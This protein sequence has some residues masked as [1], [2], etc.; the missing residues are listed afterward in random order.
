MITDNPTLNAI[1]NLSGYLQMLFDEDILILITDRD[2]V[3]YQKSSK[4]FDIGAH[5][6]DPI[7]NNTPIPKVIY[8][9]QPDNATIP[10]EAYGMEFTTTILPIKEDG[11]VVGTLT[12]GRSASKKVALTA[13][14][15]TLNDSLSQIALA[16]NQITG[17]VQ[18]LATMNEEILSESKE[19]SE[20]S[21]E[22]DN[23]VSFIQG[24]ASQTNLLGLNAAIEASRAGEAGRGFTIVA[25]EIRKLS[26]STN[27]SIKQID[28]VIK[29]ISSSVKNITEKLI[30][31]NEA[32]QSQSAALQQI[33]ASISELKNTCQDLE[34]LTQHI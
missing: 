11:D 13:A 10:E 34:T 5:D 33:S 7:P 12:I 3:I 27:E 6:G 1:Y 2:K 28:D 18:T 8:S 32:S 15:K 21:K 30:T 9:G 29:N 17:D 24:I 25:Q 16:I 19:A 26:N 31:S 22:T 14:T 20:A 23:V 4:D